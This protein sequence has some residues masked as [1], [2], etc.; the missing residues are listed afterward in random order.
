MQILL[1]WWT[2][3]SDLARLDHILLFQEIE[4]SDIP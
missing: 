1:N 3:M 4:G 2:I